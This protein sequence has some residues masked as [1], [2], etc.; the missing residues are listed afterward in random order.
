M[1]NIFTQLN[2]KHEQFRGHKHTSYIPQD[3]HFSLLVLKRTTSWNYI[4][5]KLNSKNTHICT[6]SIN[7]LTG[8]W[9]IT[10]LLM[11]LQMQP[12]PKWSDQKKFHISKHHN[13]TISLYINTQILVAALY[14]GSP[15]TY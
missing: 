4:E 1:D 10:I 6:N 9:T 12:K 2:L 14:F 8:K 7:S 15:K 13:V 11:A 3:V 5:I